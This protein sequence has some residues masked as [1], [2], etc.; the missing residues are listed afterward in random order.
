VRAVD[1]RGRLQSRL[2]DGFVTQA[3]KLHAGEGGQG[4]D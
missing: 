1:L 3:P 2:A 4:D